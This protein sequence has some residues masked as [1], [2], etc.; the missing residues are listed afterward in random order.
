MTNTVYRVSQYK[1]LGALVVTEKN[2]YGGVFVKQSSCIG[3]L[4]LQQDIVLERLFVIL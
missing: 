3:Y 4:S 1:L 2:Q